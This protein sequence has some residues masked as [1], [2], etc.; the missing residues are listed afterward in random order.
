MLEHIK[1][2]FKWVWCHRTKSLGVLAVAVG[3]GQ[4]HLAQLGDVLP[5]KW[6]GKILAGFGVLA[7][8]IGLFNTLRRPDPSP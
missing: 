7:F 8:L 2:P 5:P 4:G 6:Q 3:Y 1:A